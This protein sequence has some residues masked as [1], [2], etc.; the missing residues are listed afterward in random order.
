M[1]RWIEASGNRVVVG[2]CEGREDRDETSFGFSSIGNEAGD[3][4]GWGLE[5]VSETEPIS[6][7]D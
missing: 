6:G 4:G 2:E 3:V 5:L 7:D 1:V